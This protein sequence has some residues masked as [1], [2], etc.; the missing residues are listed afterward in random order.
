MFALHSTAFATSILYREVL[1]LLLMIMFAMQ[2]LTHVAHTHTLT[3]VLLIL[4]L[5]WTASFETKREMLIVFMLK[6]AWC[7]FSVCYIYISIVRSI[8]RSKQHKITRRYITRTLSD[9]RSIWKRENTHTL[10]H[11][12]MRLIFKV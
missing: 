3:N 5:D 4:A 1:T 7:M 8:R 6:Y 10:T 9:I 11:S 12:T 2:T